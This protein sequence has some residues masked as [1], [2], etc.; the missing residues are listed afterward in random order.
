MAGMLLYKNKSKKEVH[1]NHYDLIIS[2][3][4]NV[5]EFSKIMVVGTAI[6]TLQIKYSS[7]C[8][9]MQDHCGNNYV[10]FY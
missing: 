2:R 3:A 5:Y 1:N 9:N 4:N 7:Q 10:A 6:K 8:L